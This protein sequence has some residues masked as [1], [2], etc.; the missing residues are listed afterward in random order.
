MRVNNGQILSL[1]KENIVKQL[2]KYGAN[3]NRSNNYG[4]TP[5]I[6]AAKNGKLCSKVTN[7]SKMAALLF[8]SFIHNVRLFKIHTNL[9]TSESAAEL[10]FSFKISYLGFSNILKLLIKNGA[11]INAMNKENNTALL[12][13]VLTGNIK[14]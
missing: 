2:I 13:V 1:G 9:S 12:S 6:S 11:D 5:L 14:V 8:L 10:F 7:I 4:D 3:P